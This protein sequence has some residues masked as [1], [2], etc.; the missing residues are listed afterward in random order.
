MSNSTLFLAWTFNT[1]PI[2][3]TRWSILL[4]PCDHMSPVQFMQIFSSASCVQQ[5]MIYIVAHRR[6][7]EEIISFPMMCYS[8]KSVTCRPIK[9]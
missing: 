9:F 3:H 5:R 1:T 2:R 6:W 4:I 8:S 7:K